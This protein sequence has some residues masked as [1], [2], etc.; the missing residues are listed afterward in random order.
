MARKPK[1]QRLGTDRVEL[2]KPGKYFYAR[3]TDGGKRREIG[4][5]RCTVKSRA[6]KMAVAIEEALNKGEPW[7]VALERAP[8][9]AMTFNEAL[10]EFLKKGCRWGDYTLLKNA[11]I[12]ETLRHEWGSR[13]VTDIHSLDVEAYLARRR[14]E[15]VSLSTRNRHLAAI[16]SAF[17]KIHEYGHTRTNPAAIVKTLK[18]PIKIKDVLDDAEFEAL[19]AELPES[20]RRIIVCAAETG[21]RRS[22]L[23]R[24]KWEDIDLSASELRVAIAKNKEFRVVPLTARLAALMVE[25]KA[26]NTPHPKTPVFPTVTSNKLL[27][28]AAKRAG[29][30]KTVT[31]HTFRHQFATRALEAGVSS[32]HLQAIGGW[33]SPVMLQRYG[34]IRN[35]ALHEQMAKLNGKVSNG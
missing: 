3:F 31:L 29:I 14:D 24:L 13:A 33:K 1:E 11:H 15:G 19:L 10:D 23:E 20:D 4:L 30:E 12:L 27:K 25:M 18:E 17:R 5:N 16:K 28:D 22:E 7:E 26:E 8:A 32:F 2:R 34:K 9:G 6:M 35:K 21:M